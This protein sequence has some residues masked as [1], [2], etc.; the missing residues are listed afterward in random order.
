MG[1]K[2]KP[3]SEFLNACNAKYIVKKT[4]FKSI[5]NPSCIDLIITDK[6]GTFQHTNVFETGISDH[7]KLVTT[8]MKAKFT[9][10]APNYV[11]YHDYKN[12]N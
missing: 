9:M 11:Y 1:R 8:V 3:S 4:C 10:A 12:K 6:P 5:E 2:V 7:H